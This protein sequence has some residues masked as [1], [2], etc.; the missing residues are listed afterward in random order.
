[1]IRRRFIRAFSGAILTT[2]LGVK[3]WT[4]DVVE[5]DW[6]TTFHEVW[7]GHYTTWHLRGPGVDRQGEGPL[8]TK[9][10]DGR[11]PGSTYTLSTGY[12]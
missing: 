2:L 6:P 11:Q 9:V 8:S 10:F 12:R 5:E 4:L 3:T 1:M 7:G